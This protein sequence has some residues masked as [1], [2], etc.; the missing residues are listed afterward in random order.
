LAL[1]NKRS[2]RGEFGSRNR[3]S[4]TGRLNFWGEKRRS[5]GGKRKVG[6]ASPIVKGGGQRNEQGK[7]KSTNKKKKEKV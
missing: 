3:K 5:P 6:K 4:Y 7:G 2:G 1:D